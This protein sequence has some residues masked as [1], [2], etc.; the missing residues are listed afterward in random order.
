MRL[1]GPKAQLSEAGHLDALGS[2]ACQYGY[3]L[4]VVVDFMF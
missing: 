1:I 3:F 2:A 4:G